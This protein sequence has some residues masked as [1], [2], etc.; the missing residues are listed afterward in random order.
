MTMER[1]R[2][3]EWFLDASWNIRRT[4]TPQDNCCRWLPESHLRVSLSLQVMLWGLDPPATVYYV[5]V[6]LC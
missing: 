1:D 2:A 5:I 6:S 4:A 3:D